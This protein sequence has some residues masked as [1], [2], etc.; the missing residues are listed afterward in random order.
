[1]ETNDKGR[2]RTKMSFQSTQDT[3]QE[4]DTN[5][6][7]EVLLKAYIIAY[8]IQD[9]EPNDG[10]EGKTNIVYYMWQKLL[11]RQNA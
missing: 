6:K 4:S 9:K 5:M 10:T 2:K 11:L 8:L 1:M 7:Q 3:F